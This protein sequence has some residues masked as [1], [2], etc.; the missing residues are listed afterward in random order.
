MTLRSEIY[1]D[2]QLQDLKNILTNA[3][4]DLTWIS[5]SGENPS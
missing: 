5:L 4:K 2:I 3:F 1:I